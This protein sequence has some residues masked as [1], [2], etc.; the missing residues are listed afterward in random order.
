MRDS[1][2]I[3]SLTKQYIQRI[4]IL[5]QK[6]IPSYTKLLLHFSVSHEALL[7]GSL[8]IDLFLKYAEAD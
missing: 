6:H 7:E 2:P 5:L 3:S 1:H 8:I 4:T